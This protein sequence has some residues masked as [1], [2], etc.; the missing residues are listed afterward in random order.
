MLFPIISSIR[1]QDIAD[2]TLTSYILFRFYVLFRGTNV[3]RVIAGIALLWFFQRMA[4]SLGLVVT[5]WV[6]QGFTAVAALIIII[7]FRNEIRSVLQ[8]QNLKA[9]VWGFSKS[10][11]NTPVEIIVQSVYELSRS[12]IGGLIVFAGKEDLEEFVQK[13]IP[14]QGLATREMIKSIFWPGG[15]VHDGA[16]VVR[17]NRVEEVGVILPLSHRDDLPHTFGTRHRAALGLAETTDAMIIVISEESGKVS[18]AKDSH[19]VE[20]PDNVAL[21]SRLREHLGIFTTP[22]RF[23]KKEKIELGVA[24]LFSL[25]LITGVWFSFTRG[26]DTLISLEV[27]LEYI[28]RNPDMEILNT[29]ANTVNIHIRGSGSLVKTIRQEQVQVRIDLSDAVAGPNSFTINQGSIILPPGVSLN[30]VEPAAIE[31]FLDTPVAKAVPVQVDW[32]GKLAEGLILAGVTLNP[33]TI[34]IVGG[35]QIVGQIDTIYTEKVQLNN[36]KKSG[37]VTVGL[38]LNPASIK[39]AP[40]TKDKIMVAYVLKERGK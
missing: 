22:E 25:L 13:G 24:A 26:M 30:R 28:N 21:A 40:D 14:W 20:I 9:I 8:A 23:M 5:S 35:S 31:V 34:K 10:K 37:S 16:V 38:V 17:G 15:P 29:S 33:Q 1:W 39:L 27:P 19:I 32:A 3:F 18:M 7:V 11:E 4:V 36:L 12:R 2:I 6:M